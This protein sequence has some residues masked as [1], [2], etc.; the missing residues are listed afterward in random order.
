MVAVGLFLFCALWAFCIFAR[1]A[2]WR[3]VC[4]AVRHPR[5]DG[6]S[7][8]FGFFLNLQFKTFTFFKGCGKSYNLHMQ[9]PALHC[10]ALNVKIFYSQ[11][12]SVHLGGWIFIGSPFEIIQRLILEILF[13]RLGLFRLPGIDCSRRQIRLVELVPETIPKGRTTCRP[14]RLCR[15]PTN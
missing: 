1:F 14:S 2:S 7:F 8:V 10:A 6:A 9:K 3:S 13:R 4:V 12:K 5:E 11:N 15:L